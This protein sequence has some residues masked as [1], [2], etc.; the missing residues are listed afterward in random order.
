MF[1]FKKIGTKIMASFGLVLL[2]F[3]GVTC[4]LFYMANA[5]KNSVHSF[6]ISDTVVRG[7]KD[8]G[9]D[10]DGADSASM[11]LAFYNDT[12]YID[13]FN[14]Q[15]DK[16][17]TDKEKIQN[18]FVT[19]NS[20]DTFA[21]IIALQ[22][23]YVDTFHNLFVPAWKTGSKDK[24]MIADAALG[25]KMDTLDSL[26]R[27]IMQKHEKELL[28]QSDKIDAE[29]IG[30][31]YTLLFALIAAVIVG[32]VIAILIGRGIAKPIITSTRFAEQIAAG[33]LLAEP[34]D[35]KLQDEV[36]TLIE[37]LNTMQRNLKEMVLRSITTTEEVN[38]AVTSSV[39]AVNN[40]ASSSE[41]IAASTEQIAGGFQEIAA[42]A[43]EIS[44][45]SDEL[46]NSISEL[47]DKAR[48]GNIEAQ[49]IEARARALKKEALDAQAKAEAI[50]EREKRGLEKAIEESIVVQKIGELTKGI[51][52]IADQTNLL[53]LN[54]AIEAARAGES[55][56]GFAVVADEVRKLAEQS[57]Q[58]VK[59]IEELVDK[60]IQ[61]QT[62]LS[63][64]AENTLRFI[65]DVVTQDYKKMMETGNQYEH[66]ASSVLNMTDEFAMIAQALF[67]MVNAV[68]VAINNVTQT[69]SQG[70]AG[71]EEVSSAAVGVSEE[72]EKINQSMGELGR[73]ADALAN[74]VGS[75]DV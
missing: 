24:L 56:R 49:N 15:V 50:Y 68:A 74:T 54:A 19:Q 66:D 8:M 73:N 13:S 45:S 7:L 27:G 60:V 3:I 71:A 37:A 21:R 63:V 20:R 34:I 75:F 5:V 58:T 16:F 26:A 70:A 62:A 59:E 61:A 48:G 22:K 40:V 18:L 64:G 69:I 67:N 12:K 65:N 11:N 14:Q 29:M 38:T 23:D 30:F 10:L 32:I 1:K 4:Y 47:N 17:N 43:E 28:A 35:F 53:A 2:I 33:N 44:A 72:L 57:S 36:G 25:S 39:E 52:I 9:T 46:K 55:G 41:E 31:I 42:A 51:S 6:T